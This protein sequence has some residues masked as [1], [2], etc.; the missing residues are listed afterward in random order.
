VEGPSQWSVGW[1]CARRVRK[2]STALLERAGAVRRVRE[3]LATTRCIPGTRLVWRAIGAAT[4]EMGGW[5]EG[6][7]P[8]GALVFACVCRA[9]FCY[10]CTGSGSTVVDVRT[11]AML[12]TTLVNGTAGSV[13]RAARLRVQLEREVGR[14]A[15]TRTEHATH[16][17]RMQASQ[18]FIRNGFNAQAGLWPE[19]ARGNVKTG[20]LPERRIT[21]CSSFTSAYPAISL[22][23]CSSD[24]IN[25]RLWV[26][27][28]WH[29]R[30]LRIR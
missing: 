5:T 3:A 2:A 30:V 11:G 7:V 18:F 6:L 17:V 16:S 20:I 19:I 8:T 27:L 10:R 13:W 15:S 25:Q 12:D 23:R 28:G 24:K 21:S 9:T 26:V 22:H 29:V 4:D 14:A 1:P